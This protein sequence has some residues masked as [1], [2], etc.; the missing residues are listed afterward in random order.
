[1]S[2]HCQPVTLSVAVRVG[3]A[4]RCFGGACSTGERPAWRELGHTEDRSRLLAFARSWLYEH[5][6]LRFATAIALCHSKHDPQ[7]RGRSRQASS[8]RNRCWRT[9]TMA[10]FR[11]SLVTLHTRMEPRCKHGCGRFRQSTRRARSKRCSSA[12]RSVRAWA[13]SASV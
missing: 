8:C 5:S 10:S 9:C 3:G 6:S 11:H 12:S 13:P 2:T 7:V 1:M 4:P